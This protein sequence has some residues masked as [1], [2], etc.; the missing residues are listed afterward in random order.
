MSHRTNDLVKLAQKWLDIHPFGCY[1]I[2]AELGLI[3]GN[4]Y[5][6]EEFDELAQDEVDVMQNLIFVRAVQ[7]KKVQD[8]AVKVSQWMAQQHVREK[9]GAV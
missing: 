3:D 5:S 2:G 7:N 8:L 9:S 6:M 1:M 4:K